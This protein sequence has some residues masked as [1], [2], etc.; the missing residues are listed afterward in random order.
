MSRA[1][2]LLLTLAI[3]VLGLGATILGTSATQEDAAIPPDHPLLG[4]W[5]TT[6]SEPGGE[7]ILLIESWSPE[8]TII[9]V[10][11]LVFAVGPDFIVY[12]TPALGTWEAT[13]EDSGDF[14]VEYFASDVEGNLVGIVTV[15]G[16][17]QAS[18]DGQTATG[19][20]AFS[21]VDPAGNVIAAGQ[22]TDEATRLTVVPMDS[23]A[24]PTASPAA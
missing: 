16:N 23:L 9:A 20:F 18:D 17:R 13:G 6:S 14:T 3:V 8:G 12:D 1:S 4:T 24:T 19:E 10:A 21:V 7:E 5:R 11:P 22:G 2:S 15:S